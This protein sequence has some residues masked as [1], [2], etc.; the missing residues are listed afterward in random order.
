M[1][2]I[3]L[4]WPRLQ[5]MPRVKPEHKE[6]RR[7]QIVV[8][9]RACFARLGF[10]RTTLQDVFAEANLSAGCVYNY[11]RSKEDLVLA[12]AEGRHHDEQQVITQASS[13]R[14]PIEGLRAIAQRFTDNYLK[15][16]GRERR[17]IA[18]QT[19]AEAVQNR[20][21]L[22]AVV[23]G[24]E[25]PKTQIAKLISR[26]Q[27]LGKLSRA[28]D[29]EATARTIIA[30]FHGFILQKLWEPGFDPAAGFA[31]FE[32]F[33]DSLS[34]ESDHKVARKSRCD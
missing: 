3:A 32:K 8:A 27:A 6:E 31:V 30:M 5:L 4:R 17:H 33:L 14:D 10:H 26:G 13:G 12:I 34:V 23:A 9:A 24:F 15:E 28:V 18:I 11:F 20:A 19:W 21:I 25:E 2:S 22:R 7:A 16:Q 1:N 29:A